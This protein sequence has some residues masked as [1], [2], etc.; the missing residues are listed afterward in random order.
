MKA[1]IFQEYVQT[2]SERGD[3]MFDK[4]RKVYRYVDKNKA[5]EDNK[6]EVKKDEQQPAAGL[7]GA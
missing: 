2:L 4:E 5:E 6:S 7:Q 3:A 1:R